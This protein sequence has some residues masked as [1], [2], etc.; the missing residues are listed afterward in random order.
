MCQCQF[1]TLT[2]FRVDLLIKRLGFALNCELWGHDMLSKGI[3]NTGDPL[4]RPY[5]PMILQGHKS[6]LRYY[7]LIPVCW[8][9]GHAFVFGFKARHGYL[10]NV[11]IPHLFRDGH[12]LQV[13]HYFVQ[14]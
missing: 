8:P 6:T 3:L 14:R 11:H 7:V 1:V 4:D 9:S 12:L 2:Q 5:T 13:C 10:W